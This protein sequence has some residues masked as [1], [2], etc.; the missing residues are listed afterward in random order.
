MH[1]LAVLGAL[2]AVIGASGRWMT[3][4]EIRERQLEAARRWQTS[5]P[6]NIKSSGVQNI[7][8]ANPKAS[9]FYVDGRSLPFVDFDVGPSWAGLLPISNSPNETRQLFFWFFP[10]GP[11]GSLDDLIFWTNG[12]PGCSSLEGLLQENGPFSWAWGQAKPTVNQRSWTNLSS[13]LWVEQPV[14]TGFSQGTPNAQNEDDVAAQ[15]VGFMQQFLHVFSELKGKKLYV[16]GESYAGRYVP[17]ESAVIFFEDNSKTNKDIANYIYENPTQLNLSLQGIWINDPLISRWVVQQQIPAVDFVKK[18]AD[19]FSFNQTFMNY[20]EKKAA[21]CNYT[22]YMDKYVTYPPA[23]LLPLPGDS[24]YISEGCDVWDT[25]F[26]SALIINPAFNVY[27]IWDTYPTLWDVLG[28]LGQESP[29]YFN[30]TDVKVAIHAPV[31]TE[32]LECTNT[33]VFPNGDSSLS[34]ALTVLPNVIEKSQRAVIV[35]G[36]A[37]FILIAN[38]TRI[39]IQNMTWNGLQGFQTPI[40]HESFIVDDVGAYGTMHSERGLTYYEVALSGHMLPEFAPVAAF[41]IMQYLMGFR[42][43]P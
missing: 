22:G 14:G 21:T 7:T 9:E 15:L 32:W 33:N 3:K 4:H 27:R 11:Q 24:V 26:D 38:G 41:Q 8:F 25:I 29:I 42:D 37:D 36:L 6:Q 28:F 17:C 43:A 30:R 5:G 18:H 39:A 16:T 34:P 1:L 35:H 40:A 20:L 13:V 31:D 19:I 23:G 12:G 2:L 10:P